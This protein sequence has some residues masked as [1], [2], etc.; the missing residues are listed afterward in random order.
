MR[1]P[2]SVLQRGNLWL[3]AKLWAALK[4]KATETGRSPSQV[5]E[6]ALGILGF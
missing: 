6:S 3:P 2:N 1:E 4:A 5:V